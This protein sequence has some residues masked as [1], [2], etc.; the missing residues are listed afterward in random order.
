MILASVTLALSG[1]WSAMNSYS[2]AAKSKAVTVDDIG[3]AF[4]RAGESVK[5]VDA[6]LGVVK[7]EW[8]TAS[9]GSIWAENLRYVAVIGRDGVVTLRAETEVCQ[10]LLNCRDMK[11]EGLSENHEA[12]AALATKLAA[13]LDATLTATKPGN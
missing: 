1:C 3:K 4:A 5:E 2:I 10:G 13:D 9:G 12:I 11:G 6:Q 7:T 8:K